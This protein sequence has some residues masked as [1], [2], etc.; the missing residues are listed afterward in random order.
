MKNPM[1]AMKKEKDYFI[2]IDSDGCAFDS[3]EIKHKECFI[4]NTINYWDLQPIAKYAREAAEFVNLYSKWRGINRFPGLIHVIDLLSEREECVRRGYQPPDMGALQNWIREETK[5]GNPALIEKVQTHPLPIL[6]K[7]LEWSMA[8]NKAIE[9]MVRNIPPFPYVRESLG[10]MTMDCDIVVV[11]ATP[12]EALHREWQEHGID[13]FA[14]VI[15]GQEIGT[16]KES[17]RAAA[18]K[19]YEPDK[20][21]MIGDAPGDYEAA[22]AAH[23]LFYPINPGKEEESWERFYNEG[24]ERFIKGT[25]KGEYEQ[26]LKREFDTFLP[27]RP[28]WEVKK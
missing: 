27:D 16:K 24:L 25:Y 14:K 11:S 4:P 21:L 5:L 17:M 15:A 10:A 22:R 19:G 1:L 3:M 12:N 9:D 6:V 7:T 28:W 8:V 20:M 26:E 2:G 13:G 23:A 18:E